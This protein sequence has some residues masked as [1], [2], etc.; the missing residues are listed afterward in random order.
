M[1]K[2]TLRLWMLIVSVSLTIVSCSDKEDD[3][4]QPDNPTALDDNDL[5]KFT[6]REVPV[7]RSGVDAGTV[8]LRYY[9]DMGDVAYISTAD[10]H[11]M[12]IP[13]A[14][15]SVN[16]IEEGLYELTSPTG[17]AIVDTRKE[18]FS[19]TD[20][21]SFTN[22]MGL[23]KHNAGGCSCHFRLRQIRHRPSR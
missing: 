14:P 23:I 16:C 10:Y 6:E 18:T 20:Y 21:E 19:S 13:G 2:K 15:Y 7:N 9:E 12:M 17:K 8:T 1:N 3:P 11:R 4:S 22:M 5:K